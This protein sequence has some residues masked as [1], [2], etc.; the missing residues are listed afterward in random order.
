[1][2]GIDPGGRIHNFYGHNKSSDLVNRF[3]LNLNAYGLFDESENLRKA[4][5][6][7]NDSTNGFEAGPWFTTKTKLI[8]I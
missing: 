3:D 7:C 4:P 2:I 1:V 5:G 6:Y 8:I